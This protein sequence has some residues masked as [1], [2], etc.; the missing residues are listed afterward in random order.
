MI[1]VGL[2]LVGFILAGLGLLGTVITTLL[3]NWKNS[4]YIGASIVTAV[5]FT[6]G[7]WMECAIYSTGITQCDIYNSLLSLPSDLQASQALMVTSCAISSLACIV[8]VMG[9]KCTIFA[10]GS[11]AKDRVAVTGGVIF[12]L[13]GVLCFIPMVWNT[14]VVLQDFYNPL[15]PDSAKYEMGEA[16]YLGIVSALLTLLGGCILSASCPPRESETAYRSAYQS[17]ALASPRP[18]ISHTQKPKSEF[19]AYNLTGYV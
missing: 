7:L 11:P 18:S 10:Q 17:K 8:S 5:G 3:P 6:K 2:Q 1:S 14:H 13:G 12:I 16:M 9:M 15:I 4:S 19:S